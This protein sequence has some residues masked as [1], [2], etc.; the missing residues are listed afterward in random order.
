MNYAEI[1]KYDVSNGPGVRTTIFFSGCTLDCPGC[2]NKKLQ[3]F[4]YGNKFDDEVVNEFIE[5]SKSEHVV[6]INIL[7]GEPMLQNYHIMMSFLKKLRKEVNKPIWL[8]TGFTFENLL[9]SKEKSDILSMVDV[10]VDG[11]FDANL[12]DL[13]LK[14]RGSSNQRVIDVKKSFEQGKTVLLDE[15]LTLL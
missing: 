8:W 4:W 7:G 2:F 11:K 5:Y 3:D 1:R 15:K 6:G 13:S 12:K 9:K 10:V 14:Y